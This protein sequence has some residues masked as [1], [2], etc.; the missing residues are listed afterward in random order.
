MY[1]SI[2]ALMILGFAC[3]V[4]PTHAAAEKYPDIS[5]AQLK[6]DMASKSVTIIDANGTD[7]YREAHIRHQLR[8]RQLETG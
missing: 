7:S 6:A 5:I 8:G 3:L 4:L 1:R 2:L